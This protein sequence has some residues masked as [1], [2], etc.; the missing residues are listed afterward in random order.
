MPSAGRF[1]EILQM[2]IYAS[3]PTE[4]LLEFLEDDEAAEPQSSCNKWKVLVVDD[5]AQ[6]HQATAFAL[7]RATVCGRQLELLHAY[8]ANEARVLLEGRTDVAVILL[9]APR[10]PVVPAA[11]PRPSSSSSRSWSK[12]LPR[13]LPPST[14]SP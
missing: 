3:P 13:S 2:N 11:T 12:A 6:V 9:D 4:E 7:N 5:D 10:S 14:R 1:S 8:S